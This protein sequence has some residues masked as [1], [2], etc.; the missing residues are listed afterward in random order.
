MLL[1]GPRAV[2]KAP[3]CVS[4]GKQNSVGGNM[5]YSAA[6]KSV[7]HITSV[8]VYGR[9]DVTI[10]EGYEIAE[11]RQPKEGEIILTKVEAFRTT[12]KAIPASSDVEGPR[13]ILRKTVRNTPYE[14]YGTSAVIAPE[15][16]KLDQFKKLEK[17][18]IFI[19]YKGNNDGFE[20]YAVGPIISSAFENEYRWTLKVKKAPAPKIVRVVRVLEYVG[21]ESW[22]ESTMAKNAVGPLGRNIVGGAYNSPGRDSGVRELSIF[23]EEVK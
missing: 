17:G 23:K 5:V 10:P 21:P 19:P 20:S 22:I 2:Y 6:Q 14:V 15:G 11:F 16:Y 12:P 8:D 3:F 13:F 18:D 9:E 7:L 1:T 4:R